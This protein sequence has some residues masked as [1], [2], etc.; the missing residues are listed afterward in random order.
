VL[1]LTQGTGQAKALTTLPSSTKSP[2]L[3]NLSVY[4]K[5]ELAELIRKSR[6]E[7]SVDPDQNAE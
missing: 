3:R 7:D 4:E 6:D 5:P 2:N 1:M